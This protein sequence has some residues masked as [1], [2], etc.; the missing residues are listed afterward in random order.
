[1]EAEWEGVYIFCHSQVSDGA[2]QSLG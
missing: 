2:G 1:M